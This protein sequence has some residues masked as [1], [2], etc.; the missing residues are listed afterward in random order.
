VLGTFD[1][2]NP[3]LILGAILLAFVL[4]VPKGLIPTIAEG[5]KRLV[6]GGSRG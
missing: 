3:S 1:V 6:A 5:G 4:L 2:N